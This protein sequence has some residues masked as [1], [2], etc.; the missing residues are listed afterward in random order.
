M[1]LIL[2]PPALDATSIVFVDSITATGVLSFP[3]AELRY[4][5]ASHTRVALLRRMASGRSFCYVFSLASPHEVRS[6][7]CP[8]LWTANL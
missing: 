4:W 1:S 5:L 6:S 3:L 2:V 7:C 8:W